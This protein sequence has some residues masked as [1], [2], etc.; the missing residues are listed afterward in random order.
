MLAQQI[1]VKT[2]PYAKMCGSIVRE[3]IQKEILEDRERKTG[4]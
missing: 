1:S 4:V 3:A 2:N